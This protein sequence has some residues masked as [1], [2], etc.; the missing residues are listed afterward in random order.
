MYLMK[1]VAVFEESAR[2]FIALLGGIP[3]ALWEKPALGV[4]DVRSLAGHT[5]RAITTIGDY[6]SNDT[7]SSADCPDAETYLLGAGAGAA[8]EAVARRG[9]AAGK[10]LPD[11]PASHVARELDRVLAAIATEPARRIV[12]VLG[13]RTI[14]LAEYLRTRNFELVVHTLDLS[15]ATG[16]PHSL[17]ARSI[18]EASSLAAR[19]AAR[20]GNGEA[21]LLALTGRLPLPE[22]FSVV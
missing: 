17:P 20:R 18:E 10:A 7:P 12:S 19:V 14:P 22:G 9:I 3:P 13:G 11:E 8:S 15:R 6:L 1:N 21:L 16:I 4:W 5:V 2:A